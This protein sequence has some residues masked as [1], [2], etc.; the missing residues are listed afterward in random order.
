MSPPLSSCASAMCQH[1]GRGGRGKLA[2]ILIRT[3]IHVYVGNNT[4]TYQR[5]E[6]LVAR[7]AA[8]LGLVHCLGGWNNERIRQWQ[9]AQRQNTTL[10]QTTANGTEGNE[11]LQLVRAVGTCM[12]GGIL[13]TYMYVYIHVLDRACPGALFCKLILFIR[14]LAPTTTSRPATSRHGKAWCG[15][16][17]FSWSFRRRHPMN[18]ARMS[19]SVA[20][21]RVR[22]GYAYHARNKMNGFSIASSGCKD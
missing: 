7:T 3:Y 17:S 1:G 13:N 9:K 19:K 2:A 11:P 12:D 8:E 10:K 6:A 4:C 18:H 14:A 21:H 5:R 15:W 20:K 22:M 16:L